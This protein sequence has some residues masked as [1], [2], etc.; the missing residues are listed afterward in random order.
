MLTLSRHARWTVP[1]AAVA[2]VAAVTAGSL[3][4]AAQAAPPLPARTPGQ[5]L[6][7]VAGTTSPPPPLSGTVV[8]TTSLGLPQLPGTDNPASITSMLTGSH[9]VRVW[10]DGPQRIRLA[11]LSQFG[12][13]DFI[14]NG[15]TGWLWQ[16]SSNSVTRYTLP[17]HHAGSKAGLQPAPGAT[18]V[19]PQQAAR[20]ALAAA[21]PSTKV[22]VDR[23]VTVAGQAAYQLVLTPRD[24]RSL[25]RRI[26]IALDG[27]HPQVPLRVQ[28]FAQGSGSPA[29]QVGYTSISYVK[30]AAANFR[31]APPAGA[32]VHAA[33]L[34]SAPGQR[35]PESQAGAKLMG[36][37]WLS[38]AVLPASVLSGLN[39]AGSAASAAGQAARSAAGSGTGPGTAQML[40][41]LLKSARPVHGRWGSGR[42]LRTSLISVL[43]TS[44]G[45]VL[46]GVVTPAVLYA[47]A[48]QVK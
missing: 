31:F 17:A 13:T 1:A 19:T 45:H 43:I 10:Y 25:V 47:D 15:A 38:V 35:G 4:S 7:A 24:S 40:S 23:N 5:L 41:A 8:E 39:G 48:A 46:A 33:G 16:S 9:T 20:Q 28:V 3:I 27:Q 37:H 36:S 32:H 21:G 2:A 30:P 26:T 14:R 34:P 29:I 44:N 11:A 12:E 42:L 6:A 22:S 18:P